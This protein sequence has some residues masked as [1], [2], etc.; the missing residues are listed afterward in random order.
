M[1]SGKP[2]YGTN[3]LKW[4]LLGSKDDI[5][6][7]KVLSRSKICFIL[8]FSPRCGTSSLASYRLERAWSDEEM[9]GVVPFFLDV[10]EKRDLSNQVAVEFDIKHESPQALLIKDGVAFYTSSHWIS[11]DE[12]RDIV[13]NSRIK[14]EN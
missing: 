2:E 4:N 12:I 10:I 9:T 11:Y 6:K 14:S 7:L 5:E 3:R 8:K 1:I 13:N